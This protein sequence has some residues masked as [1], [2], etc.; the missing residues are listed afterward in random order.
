MTASFRNTVIYL[1]GYPGVGKYTIAKEIAAQEDFI[2]LDNQ[3]INN[4]IFNAVGADGKTPL[5]PGVWENVEKVRDAVLDSIEHLAPPHLNYVLTN[6]V[7]DTPA[8]REIFEKIRSVFERRGSTIIPVLLDCDLDEH[9]L[10][11][12]A[13]GRKERFKD[14][15][16][17]SAQRYAKTSLI[18]D[19]LPHSLRLDITGVSPDKAAAAILAHAKT[20][21]SNTVKP[22]KKMEPL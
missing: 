1:I 11:I 21:I 15:N 8:D 22:A 5:P 17:A 20:E 19:P 16:P 13:D 10:R 18:Q 2:V 12:A 3:L 6:Y 4:P 9:T 7:S 14:V